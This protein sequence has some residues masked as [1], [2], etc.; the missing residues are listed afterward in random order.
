[1]THEPKTSDGATQDARSR[2]TAR[3][4]CR[5]FNGLLRTPKEEETENRRERFLFGAS[6]IAVLW[7]V[8]WLA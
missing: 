7:L 3:G 5:Y 1:M 2:D 6:V 8:F 4:L